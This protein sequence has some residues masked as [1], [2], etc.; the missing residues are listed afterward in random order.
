MINLSAP[1]RA[2][3][4]ASRQ[5]WLRPL[6]HPTPHT[7]GQLVR[8]LFLLCPP[9]QE[10]S[11]KTPRTTRKAAVAPTPGVDKA[12]LLRQAAGTPLPT[13]QRPTEEDAEEEKQPAAVQTEDEAEEAGEEQPRSTGGVR[14]QRRRSSLGQEQQAQRASLAGLATPVFWMVLLTAVAAGLA[15]LAVPYCQQHDCAQLARNLPELARDAGLAGY[16][17]AAEASATAYKQAAEASATAYKQAAEAG[18]TAYKQVADAGATAYKQAAEAG[19]T[20]YTAARAHALAAADMLQERWQL[21]VG[22]Q[23]RGAGREQ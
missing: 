19:A 8:A 6:A 12:A 11:A 9:L 22:R 1:A 20:A 10:S 23:G 3:T 17:R 21:L 7:H 4:G 2:T 15:A 16:M 13:G 5:R 14:R 18:A